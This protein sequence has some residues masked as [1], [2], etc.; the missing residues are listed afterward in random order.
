MST[1]PFYHLIL[2]FFRIK[3]VSCYRLT[4]IFQLFVIRSNACDLT[5]EDFKLKANY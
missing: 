2:Q 1:K 5:N 4:S 3:T